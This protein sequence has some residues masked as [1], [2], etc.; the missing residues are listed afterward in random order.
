[1]KRGTV[2]HPKLLALQAA[3]ELSR[4]EAVGLLECLWHFTANYAPSAD[5]GRWPNLSIA[6]FIGWNDD[7]DKLVDALVT[8]GWLDKHKTHRLVVHDWHDHADETVIKR[9]QRAGSGMVTGKHP[10][11]NGKAVRQRPTTADNGCLPM[12]TPTPTPKPVKRE[13][14]KKMRIPTVAECVEHGKTIGVSADD[15]EHFH[16]YHT[17]RGW[18][19]GNHPM[20]DWKAAMQTWKRNGSLFGAKP[21]DNAIKP[22]S[23]EELQEE[24]MQGELLNGGPYRTPPADM[25]P[26]TDVQR[27]FFAEVEKQNAD[28]VRKQQAEE[29]FARSS[30]GRKQ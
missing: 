24:M 6:Q 9:L 4:F 7:P 1:M 17:S 14:A 23:L 12:P 22:A 15:S 25:V 3:L 10:R 19:V 30:R 5:V 27:R 18:V 13:R 21:D 16:N 28:P 29:Y 26:K 2:E 20:R 11:L 8:T